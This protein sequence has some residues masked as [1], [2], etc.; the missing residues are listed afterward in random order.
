MRRGLKR[1]DVDVPVAS[2]VAA[3][4]CPD[5]KGTETTLNVGMS[6][7]MRSA[8]AACPDEKGTETASAICRSAFT[9]RLQPPAPMRRGL[10]LHG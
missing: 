3:A 7:L 4:A 1:R 10:K 8:A 6:E 5:E 9:D 2:G